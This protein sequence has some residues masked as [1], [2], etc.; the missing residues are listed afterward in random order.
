MDKVTRYQNL[1]KQHLTQ[2]ADFM[3]SQPRPGEEIILAFDDHHQHYILMKSRWLDGGNGGRS[4]HIPLRVSIKNEKIWI[5][6]DH[7]EDGIATFFLDNDVSAEDIVLG[8]QPPVM[9]SHA[10][11]KSLIDSGEA[12]DAVDFFHG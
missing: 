10:K 2:W 4:Q 11:R 9:R 3:K 6:D 8:F 12:L 1:I 5:E 7:T